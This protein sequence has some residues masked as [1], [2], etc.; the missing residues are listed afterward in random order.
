LT[1]A[2]RRAGDPSAVV[3]QQGIVAEL[4]SGG[5]MGFIRGHAVGD[6]LPF[7]LVAMEGHLLLQFAVEFFAAGEKP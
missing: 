5:E 2:A 4:P 6:K 3:P 7:P 1:D